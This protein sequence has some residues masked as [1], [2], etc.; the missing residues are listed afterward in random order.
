[1][2]EEYYGFR[3]PVACRGI[4]PAHAGRI[5]AQQNISETARDHPRACGKNFSAIEARVIAWGSP[6]RMREESLLYDFFR[7]AAG[8]TPAHAGRMLYRS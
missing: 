7:R 6:P 5:V 3:V 1:M 2:R 8:I 4:T